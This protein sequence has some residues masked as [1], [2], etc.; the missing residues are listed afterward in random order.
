MRTG[1]YFP[2][3]HRL[4]MLAIYAAK[5]F[6]PLIFL[7]NLYLSRL[8]RLGG[9]F[10]ERVPQEPFFPTHDVLGPKKALT[11]TLTLHVCPNPPLGSAPSELH[12]TPAFFS[13]C[14]A[15]V[16]RWSRVP[17]EREKRHPSRLFISPLFRHSIQ[18]FEFMRQTRHNE[19]KDQRTL[20]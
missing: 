15:R 18:L 19:S 2:S 10:Q 12:P 13:P 1:T 5:I 9:F 8:S 4:K 11:I 16:R 3:I 6:L 20:L 17:G 14:F 7:G